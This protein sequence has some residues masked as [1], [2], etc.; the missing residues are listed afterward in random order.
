M[1]QNACDL[2]SSSTCSRSFKLFYL[3]LP[4][5]FLPGL[6]G[7]DSFITIVSS[8]NHTICYQ[9]N[10]V[11]CDEVT[12]DVGALQNDESIEFID[13]TALIKVSSNGTSAVFKVQNCMSAY[14]HHNTF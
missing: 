2:D 1:K 13:G 7:S 14:N 4:M 6:A 3:L 12:L 11:S 5:L 9:P 8:S 10:V